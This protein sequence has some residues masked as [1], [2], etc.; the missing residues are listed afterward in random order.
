MY[1]TFFGPPLFFGFMFT[2]Q[3]AYKEVNFES[4]CGRR[5]VVVVVVLIDDSV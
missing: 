3:N 2:T 5:A 4:V 1:D